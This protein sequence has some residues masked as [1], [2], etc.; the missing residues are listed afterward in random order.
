LAARGY[1][2]ADPVTSKATAKDRAE[3]RRVELTLMPE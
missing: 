1:G 2:D 3:N